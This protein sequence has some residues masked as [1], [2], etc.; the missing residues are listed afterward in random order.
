MR[1]LDSPLGLA[2]VLVLAAHAAPVAAQTYRVDHTFKLGGDGFWDYIAL[3][4][5]SN[6]LFIGRN[7]R[8]MV[9]DPVAGKLLGEVP[10]LN[11]AHG[12][13]IDEASGHGF[14]TSGGDATVVIFDLKTLAVVG[15]TKVDDDADAILREPATGHVFT[16]NGD[17]KTASVLDTKTG[18]R[19]GTIELGAKP[20]FGVPDGKGKVYV[21]LEDTAEIAEIDAAAMKVVRRWTIAPCEDP[22]GLAI[23]TVHR[24]LFSVCRNRMMTMSAIDGAKVVAHVAIGPGAD[25]ARYDA[26]TGLAF[27]STGGDGAITVVHEDSPTDFRIVQTVQTAP[28]ARTMELDAKMHRLYTVTAEFKQPAAA[29]RRPELA[30]GT[31][32]LIELTQ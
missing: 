21:N 8:V 3:D 16:L 1:R 19:I 32:E 15:R 14:A 31:F 26:G 11:R 29:G 28:G 9:V 20:E 25:A 5:A 27:A 13:A 10:G 2:V 17:A 24:V 4:A 23:D 6:R 7:D 22:T 18:Q 30:P 12:V